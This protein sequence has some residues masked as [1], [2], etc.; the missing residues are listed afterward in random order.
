M[1]GPP[2]REDPGPLRVL[3]L[4][5]MY[6]GPADPDYG[7]FVARMC[8]ALERRGVEVERVVIDTRA[9]GA[10]RTPAKYAGLAARAARRARGCDVVYAH[11]LFPTGGIA[12]MC[13]RMARRP[14][15]VTAHGQ[16]V[17]NLRRGAIRRVSA[18]GVEG[19]SAVIAVSRWLAGE[20]AG[21][22]LLLPPVTVAD[23]GVDTAM[24]RPGDRAA[25]R[26]RL[27]LA[28]D[29]P[30]VLAVGGLTERKNPLTLLQAMPAVLARHPGARLAFVGSGPLAGAVDAGARRLGIAHAVV[31]A[32]ALPHE[33]V[34]GW[35]DACDLLALPSR[36]EPLGVV[37][38]EAMASGRPVVA[39]RVGG[40]AE[41]VPD[42]AAGALVDPLDPA[43]VAAGILRVLDDPPAAAAC[44]AA[45][46]L[47]SVDRQAARVEAV[48]RD[49][50]RRG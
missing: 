44:V 28:P 26:A 14:W 22:G 47:H 9:R 11:Y 50:A 4:S 19:A 39:T 3:C 23:M 2:E 12:A 20:L 17:A 24:F 32:G 15:V 49:A 7:A 31:R 16:D 13:G 8:A 1:S 45:A 21:S 41:V 40:A 5:N 42:P 37:A 34:A 18:A 30:L 46:A 27:G 33:E 38:L 6:P 48:L 25:A 35:M 29:G 43:S 36:V 10:V